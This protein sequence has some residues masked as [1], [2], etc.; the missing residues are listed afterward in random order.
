MQCAKIVGLPRAAG[1]V[2]AC[3]APLVVLLIDALSDAQQ[4]A[5]QTG[6]TG[7]GNEADSRPAGEPEYTQVGDYKFAPDGSVLDETP[8]GFYSGLLVFGGLVVVVL[9]I[10]YGCFRLFDPN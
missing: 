4:E 7:A 8:D 2:L 1:R 10:P 5:G 6:G 3:I 9:V